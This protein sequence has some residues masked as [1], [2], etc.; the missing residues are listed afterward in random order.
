MPKQNRRQKTA[1]ESS[2]SRYS[3]RSEE[4]EGEG[5][6]GDEGAV[7]VPYRRLEQSPH[8]TLSTHSAE[9]TFP[10]EGVGGAKGGH[11]PD[12]NHD[13]EDSM[14]VSSCWYCFL[15]R[16]NDIVYFFVIGDFI[17]L[18]LLQ[19]ALPAHLL[20]KIL[21][22][23]EKFN[24]EASVLFVRCCKFYAFDVISNPPSFL[25][26]KSIFDL[27]SLQVLQSST[28]KFNLS[29]IWF[30]DEFWFLGIVYEALGNLYLKM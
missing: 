19:S 24:G 22:Y 9:H 2:S 29:C 16:Q 8:S 21:G 25:G 30:G 14:S 23:V 3:R 13:I 6:S 12:C 1:S 17:D 15:R 4:R 10:P 11:G 28:L 26:T 27:F 18:S 5:S 7:E 20:W